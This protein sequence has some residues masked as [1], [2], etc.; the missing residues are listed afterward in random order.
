VS[1]LPL[2]ALT[3]A[4]LYGIWFLP[5]RL[6]DGGWHTREVDRADRE[7]ARLSQDDGAAGHA[8]GVRG[9]RR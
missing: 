2:F 4:I 6:R 1:P 8:V 3:A 9:M 5:W 7:A